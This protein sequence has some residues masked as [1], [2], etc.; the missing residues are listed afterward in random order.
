A[1]LP[2][3]LVRSH[4]FNY[5]E[6]FVED[7][8]N[9]LTKNLTVLYGH[10]FPRFLKG[11]RSVLPEAVEQSVKSAIATGGTGSAELWGAYTAGLAAYFRTCGARVALVETGLMG[12]YVNEACVR[13]ALPYVVHFHG[14]DAFGREL[15]ERWHSQ[16]RNFFATAAQLIVVSKAMRTQLIALGAPAERVVLAPYGVEVELPVLADPAK[17]EPQFIAVGRFVEKKGPHVTLR[18]F[19]AVQQRVPSAR[20]VMIGDGPLLRPCQEWVEKSGLAGAVTFAGVQS[21]AEVSRQMAA[22]RAFVQHSMTA[23]NGDSEGLPL[24]VLEAGAHGLPVISTNWTGHEY[25]GTAGK[26]FVTVP[27]DDRT[28]MTISGGRFVRSANLSNYQFTNNSFL[29]GVS[30]RF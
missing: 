7:H 6:T 27:F 30:W 20:L 17:S 16:Y 13:A 8:V 11:G 2:V 10:P 24:A 21:R 28:T 5:S 26:H 25:M 18:A 23:T 3:V 12:A 9:H 4:E 22:S 1:D 15:L 14:L 29:M 19:A